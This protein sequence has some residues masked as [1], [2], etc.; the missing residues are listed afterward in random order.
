[1]TSKKKAVLPPENGLTETSDPIVA[2]CAESVQEAHTSDT[3]GRTRAW[4]AIMYP[5]S[6]NRYWKQALTDTHI[7]ALISPL[8]DKDTNPDGD[9]KKPHYH[10][11]LLFQSVVRRQTAQKVFDT[12]KA[13]QCQAVKSI[14]GEARY[15]CHLDNPEKYQYPMDQVVE[16]NGADYRSMIALPSDRYE[17]IRQIICF[18]EENNICSFARLVLWTSKNQEDWFRALCD[19]CAYIVREYLESRAW[20]EKNKIDNVIENW[21]P[22]PAEEPKRS[23]G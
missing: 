15:L 14:R 19:N 23:K 21:K 2:E 13:T 18:I 5:E 12:I 10:V 3:S 8:H 11:M 4:T 1:M 6:M 17:T 20:S 16:L 9:K 7:E 22:V